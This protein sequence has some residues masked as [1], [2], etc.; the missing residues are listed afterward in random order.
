[1]EATE[2]PE[3]KKKLNSN[4]YAENL[5]L[6]KYFSNTLRHSGMKWSDEKVKEQEEKASLWK[7]PHTSGMY[8]VITFIDL[9]TAWALILGILA[10]IWV[11]QLFRKKT[12]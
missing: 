4:A 3:E 7:R 10:L 6:E 1:V 5:L 12:V 8:Q 2:D 9:K 11:P